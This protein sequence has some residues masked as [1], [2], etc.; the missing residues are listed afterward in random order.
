MPIKLNQ[1]GWPTW[2]TR[3]FPSVADPRNCI[4][5]KGL[6]PS[7]FSNAIS[8]FK[9][10]RT[11]KSTGQGRHQLTAD[12]LSKK[13]F[14]SPPVVLDIGAS[15]GITSV[16]LIDRL[17]FK[18]YF[19]TD[20]YWDVSMIP[21]GDSAYFYNGTECILIVSDRVVVYA[22]DKGAI[23]PF[24]CLA[25]RAISRKPALDGTEIH[26]SLV[27][28]LLR[29][30]KERNDNIEIHTY[31]VFHP[32]PE[33]K[34]DLILAANILNKGYFDS[35][36]LRRALD[37]IF[38]ALKEGGTFVVVDN[39]DTENATIFQQGQETLRVEKQINK[40]TEIC[41]LILD[42]YSASQQPI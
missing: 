5:N 3:I 18:K 24:G 6:S 25:N 21:I 14:T 4:G 1:S 28:P 13:N 33:E 19:V 20:L 15:D 30:K 7:E 2:L 29:E 36:D 23:F 11:F 34:A 8:S 9:F 39:R 32:W 35:T 38:T 41:D 10:G 12:Y 37:N 40:G 42:S 16:D 26:L 31:D 27:N 22:D 17:S